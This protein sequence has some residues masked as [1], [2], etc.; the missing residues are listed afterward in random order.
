MSD[1][2]PSNASASPLIRVRDLAK[3]YTNGAGAVPVLK[4]IALDVYPG[5]MVAIMGPSGTGKSTL[6]FILGL[7]L[8]PTQ[9]SYFALGKNML[10]LNRAAQ[11]Q[12]RR[13]R[14][15]FVFQSCN[16]VENST[17]YE[18]I[19]LPLIYARINPRDR[20]RKIEEA[21]DR[22]NLSNRI[23]HRSN[24]LSGGEQQRVAIARALVNQPNII[25]ADEPTGQLDRGHS[26]LIMGYFSQFLD[27]TQTAV[28]IVTHDPEVG[29][30]CSRVHH[31][32]Y[33]TFNSH[34]QDSGH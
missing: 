28:V 23:H 29:K 4:G 24:C 27:K 13:Q 16:L 9:G 17:V 1:K 2:A 18:N 25:L 11:A 32:E 33:G 30:K 34:D 22:V 26:D 8:S 7:L 5:E 20:G 21:L 15:G 12:F 6:L 10:A 31:L 14:F 19:E 3:V